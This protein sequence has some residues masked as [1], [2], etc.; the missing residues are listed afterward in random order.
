MAKL[1]RSADR[2]VRAFMTLRYQ[3]T[4]DNVEDFVS[5]MGDLAEHVGIDRETL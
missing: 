2:A 1:Y 4:D 5:C 3:A